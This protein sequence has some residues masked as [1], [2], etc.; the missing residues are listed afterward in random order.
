MRAIFIFSILITFLITG[1][2]T[3]EVAKGITKTSQ[4]IETSIKKF[5]EPPI[6]KEKEQ[7]ILVE[8]QRISPKEKKE[9]RILIEERKISK[10]QKIASDVV[11]NQKKISTISLLGK[12]INELNQHLGQP[13]LIRKDRKTTTVRFDSRN[14]R[15]FVFM[16]SS[17]KKL[18][19]EYY[20]L[21]N[22]IGELIENQKDIESCFEEIKP[23]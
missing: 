22:D 2:A 13:Y 1:C 5:F 4:S 16:N 23:V 12:T 9:H 18:Q 14:C 20:E 7:K 3:V 17:S 10:E 19:V 6:E 15:L 11:K 21:R 8:E